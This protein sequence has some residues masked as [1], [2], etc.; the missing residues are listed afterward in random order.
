M[1]FQPCD[2]C[3]RDDELFTNNEGVVICIYG[4]KWTEIEVSLQPEEN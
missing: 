4:N 1:S 3:G 2:C